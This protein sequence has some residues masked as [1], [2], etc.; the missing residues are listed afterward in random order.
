MMRL[1]LSNMTS[2]N[3]NVS[4]FTR[5]RWSLATAASG[6]KRWAWMGLLMLCWGE[7]LAQI[8][9]VAPTLTHFN[10][11]DELGSGSLQWELNVPLVKFFSFAAS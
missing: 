9:P 7:L 4:S 8:P 3:P 5:S 10:G 6:V 11:I 2:A 1:T